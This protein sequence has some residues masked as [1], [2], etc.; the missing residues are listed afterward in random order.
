MRIPSTFESLLVAELNLGLPPTSF[1]KLMTE[2][3][4]WSFILKLHAILESALTS[5]LEKRLPA[6]D[7]DNT[8]TFARKIQLVFE[9]PECSRDPEYR[10]FFF[11]LNSLRNRFAH[12]AR[13]SSPT[14]QR[15]FE[16][17]RLRSVVLLWRLWAWRP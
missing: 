8:M 14:S 4:D 2:P 12:S 11:S 9:L 15:S 6:E 3:D 16:T 1:F 7:F 13:S 10:S 17:S 5:L